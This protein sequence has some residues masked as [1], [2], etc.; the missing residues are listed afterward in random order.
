VP[1]GLFPPVLRAPPPPPVKTETWPSC[2]RPPFRTRYTEAD[3]T[4]EPKQALKRDAKDIVTAYEASLKA[5][6][7][8]GRGRKPSMDWVPGRAIDK[9]SCAEMRA[10]MVACT[11]AG[12]SATVL[13]DRD[14]MVVELRDVIRANLP[15]RVVGVTGPVGAGRNAAVSYLQRRLGFAH[16]YS[17]RAVLR[18]AYEIRRQGSGAP[19]AG[20]AAATTLASVAAELRAAQGPNALVAL[21]LQSALNG[22]RDC[23]IECI[24]TPAE[25]QL[26]KEAGAT[27]LAID[28]PV[29]LRYSRVASDSST[30]EKFKLDEE[31]ESTITDPHRQNFKVR[32]APTLYPPSLLCHRSEG[33]LLTERTWRGVAWVRR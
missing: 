8:E 28:A 12:P 10:L 31:H 22:G 21:M 17:A 15:F 23:V 33:R 6:A 13:Q 16:I 11:S 30:L 2:G 14:Q 18:N 19:A 9:L 29:S 27:L 24:R 32:P 1:P 3:D 20:G 25:A 26:L 5:A 7:K 4:W